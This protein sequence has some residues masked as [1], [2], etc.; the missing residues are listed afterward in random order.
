MT[1]REKY[2]PFTG[3]MSDSVALNHPPLAIVLC[4]ITWPQLNSLRNGFDIITEQFGNSLMDYP[5]FDKTEEIAYRFSQ[6]GSVK[7]VGDEIFQWSD[8][9]DTWHISL[10]RRFLTFYTTD[11]SGFQAFTERL[12]PVLQLLS[13]ILKIPR[14]DRIGLRYINHLADTSLVSEIDT[15]VKSEVLGLAGASYT[16]PDISLISSINTAR[17][18]VGTASLTVKTGIVAPGEQ[19]D[20]L[21]QPSDSHTWAMSI[22]ASEVVNTIFSVDETLHCLG[23]LADISY[24]FFRYMSNEKFLTT[25]NPPQSNSEKHHA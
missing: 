1:E 12:L 24:D 10:G 6:D 13:D 2:R 11:Y 22:D 19:V 14:I 3:D 17:W 25:F 15:M 9:T 8:K 23:K 16:S 4:Q 20:Q 5:I 21:I 18:Q 7:E